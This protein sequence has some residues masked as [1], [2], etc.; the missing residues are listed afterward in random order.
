MSFPGKY[1]RRRGCN[2]P[3][4]CRTRVRAVFIQED[5][6]NSA[7]ETFLKG[8]VPVLSGHLA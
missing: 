7:E 5:L 6:S 2:S 3:N 4:P 1:K 8:E